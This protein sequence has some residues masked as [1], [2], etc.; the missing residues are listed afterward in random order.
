MRRCA[1]VKGS[2]CTAFCVDQIDGLPERY[3]ARPAATPV[4]VERN[5]AADAFFTNTGAVVRHGGTQAFYA[6]STD[7]IQMPPIESFR[8]AASYVAVRAHETVHY[9]AFRIMP[10]RRVFL[11]TGEQHRRCMSA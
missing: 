3:Y 4:V 9:A 8:D 6:P 7:H 1:Q 5:A 11:R 2:A 10:R